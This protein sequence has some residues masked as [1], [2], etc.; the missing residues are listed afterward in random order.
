MAL[1]IFWSKKAIIRFDKIL[2]YLENEFG[3]IATSVFVIKVYDMLSF[4][5]LFPEIGSMENAKFNIRGLVITKQITLFY[6]I[7]EKQII[8]LNF[9]DNRQNPKVYRF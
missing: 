8:L 5:S 6:Q 7:R 2:A 9:Y 1:K 4:I 3:E